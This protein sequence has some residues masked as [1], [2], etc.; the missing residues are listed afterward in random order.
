[1]S[2]QFTFTVP[3]KIEAAAG[4]GKR[5]KISILAYSGDVMAVGVFGDIVIDIAGMELP[6]KVT[7]LKDHDNS[8]D[9]V[10]GSGVPSVQ[11]GQLYV[12]GTVANSESGN[13]V[14][15]LSKDGVALQASVGAEAGQ[16][17]FIEAGESVTVNGRTVKSER[18]FRLIKTSRLREVTI[19]PNGADHTTAV[20][21]TA[22]RSK[23]MTE[24]TTPTADE[25]RA[26]ERQRHQQIN[27]AAAGNWGTNQDRVDQLKA[28]AIGGEL[29]LAD[30]QAQLLDIMRASRPTA[31]NMN[32]KQHQFTTGREVIEAKLMMRAGFSTLAEKTYGERV[33]D[34]ADQIRAASMVDLA[35][36][37]LESDQQSPSHNRNEMIRAAFSTISLPTALGAVI[38]KVL[39]A[40]YRETPATW[41]SFAAIRNA[42][43]FHQHTSVRPSFVGE[44]EELGKDGEIKHGSLAEA[45]LTWKVDT[46]AKML[47]VTR[48]HIINDDLSFLD[49]TA[50]LMARMALRKLS[51]LVYTAL[52]AG[53]GSSHFHADNSNLLT[54]A[55][56]IDTLGQG[57]AL[58]RNQKDAENHNLDIVP[59][60][61]LVSP[62]QETAARQLLESENVQFLA[63]STATSV[64]ER[65]SG[66]A[67]R[68]RVKLEVEPRLSNTDLFTNADS[69][70]WFLFGAT[71]DLPM[72]VG[73]L[74]GQQTPVVEFFG[75]DHDVN[76]LGVAWRC[77]HDFGTSLGDA[78]GAVMSNVA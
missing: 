48:Q 8:I 41:R 23:T 55:L 75:M 73:F 16:S 15:Q 24:T 2:D 77:Y 47:S 29:E 7:L 22:K 1:M 26:E 49:E 30:L 52:L 64:E 17:E 6:S 65:P 19:T 25:I 13:R 76:T 61:L 56:D 57:V 63:D 38:N 40:V 28:R 10:V 3:A 59:T 11:G 36:M 31:P 9:A 4:D 20:S 32:Q 69:D 66:N 42:N 58:M 72:I 54:A 68:N 70:D 39:D 21:I 53:A 37:C 45:L 43:N 67:L 78:K 33:C 35:A 51:D 18:P 5:P 44:L 27:A 50:P 34:S 60:T 74:N 14:V 71:M 46:Y 12:N 62:D